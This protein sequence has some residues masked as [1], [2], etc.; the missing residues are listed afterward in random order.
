[1]ARLKCRRLCPDGVY[2]SR[3]L[4]GS[5]GGILALPCT[6]Y[7]PVGACPAYEPRVPTKRKSIKRTKP[8]Q[9]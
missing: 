9:T 5:V 8:K 1:M 3:G 4:P 2:C 7:S 6:A